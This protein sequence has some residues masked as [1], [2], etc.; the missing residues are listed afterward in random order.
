MGRAW[1]AVARL[2]R[3][4]AQSGPPSGSASQSPSTAS[5]ARQALAAAPARMTRAAAADTA[6]RAIRQAR[7][8]RPPAAA[9][10]RSIAGGRTSARSRPDRPAALP[11]SRRSTPSP[12]CSVASPRSVSRRPSTRGLGGSSARGSKTRGCDPG[13]VGWPSRVAGSSP[14]AAP[15][16]SGGRQTARPI[17][18]VSV[19]CRD[20]Y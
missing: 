18:R 19:R 13:L 12:T 3:R 9:P 15:S 1:L 10:L 4:A 8:S 20:L 5:T 2:C 6:A 11:G 16:G 7:V 17:T 14:A